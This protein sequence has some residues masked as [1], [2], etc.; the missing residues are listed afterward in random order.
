[1][2]T[3]AR[4]QGDGR[5]GAP[6]EPGSAGA[7]GIGLSIG[8]MDKDGEPE[9]GH[10][11]ATAEPAAN[12]ASEKHVNGPTLRPEG[13][14]CATSV[15]PI[16]SLAVRVASL[17]EKAD[18]RCRRRSH[19]GAAWNGLQSMRL[20]GQTVTATASSTGLSISR[21]GTYL[22]AATATEEDAWQLCGSS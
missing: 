22:P 6:G 17:N 7:S 16:S 1:V 3:S 12:T 21:V 11:A 4:V 19:R 20:P 10:G 14:R 18:R 13:V 15:G 9:T 5:R 8:R 2:K